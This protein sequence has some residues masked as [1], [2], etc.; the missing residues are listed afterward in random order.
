MISDQDIYWAAN[1][2][3]ARHGA[4]AEIQAARMI[5]RMLDLGDLEGRCVWQRISRAIEALQAPAS[6]PP[7]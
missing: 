1:L 2:V 3:I 7:H 6:G 4:D 5:D